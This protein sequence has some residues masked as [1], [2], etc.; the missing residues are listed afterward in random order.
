[1]TKL[2]Y[3]QPFILKRAK[4]VLNALSQIKITKLANQIKMKDTRTINTDNFWQLYISNLEVQ[5]PN[6]QWETIFK[7]RKHHGFSDAVLKTLA[8]EGLIRK[9][10]DPLRYALEDV[11]A[12]KEIRGFITELEEYKYIERVQ[13][14]GKNQFRIIESRANAMSDDRYKADVMTR[15]HSSLYSDIYNFVPKKLSLEEKIEWIK[16]NH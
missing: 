14:D 9:Q 7:L 6:P 12:M 5:C 1:M 3:K 4:K 16:K 11:L 8:R 13:L 15:I 10:D 2:D